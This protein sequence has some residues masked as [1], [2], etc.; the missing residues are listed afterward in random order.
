MNKLGSLDISPLRHMKS[1]TYHDPCHLN[2]SLGIKKEPRELIQ[3]AGIEL[4]EAEGEGCCGFGG[5][6]SLH[7]RDLS[8][9]LMDK[10]VDAY[11]KTGA[12]AIVTACPGCMMQL[13]A[14]IK[15]KPVFHIIELVEEAICRG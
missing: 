12:E 7:N 4:I 5:V 8:K 11:L 9:D 3:R 10:R 13:G 1:A 14:G 15:D 2:Y 6:F